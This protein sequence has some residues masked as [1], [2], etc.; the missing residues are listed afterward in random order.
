MRKNNH[1]AAFPLAFFSL[2]SHKKDE[3][4][5]GKASSWAMGCARLATSAESLKYENSGQSASVKDALPKVHDARKSTALTPASHAIYSARPRTPFEARAERKP[6]PATLNSAQAAL[7][8]SKSD[9]TT[10]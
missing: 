1:F 7:Q 3:T 4:Y 8:D 9:C 10:N 6:C 2:L 5:A